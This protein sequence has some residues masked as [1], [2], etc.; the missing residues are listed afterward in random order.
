MSLRAILY[1]L[2]VPLASCG[3]LA[4]ASDCDEADFERRLQPLRAAIETEIGDAEAADVAACRTL[5]F[6]A[7][8]CGGPK[9]YLVYSAEASDSTRLAELAAEYG[10]VD[11][12]RN[13]V[14]ELTS[15]CMMV[16]PPDVA[17]EGGRCVAVR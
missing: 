15:D 12:E 5:P 14:C 8:P 9:T 10:A 6:G 13:R 4:G 2:L 16:T 11:A 3:L 7:K 1:V 17:L